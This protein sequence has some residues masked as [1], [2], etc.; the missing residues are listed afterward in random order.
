[1]IQISG[2]DESVYRIECAARCPR[3][4]RVF[5]RGA[6]I[7]AFTLDRSG[8]LIATLR[9]PLAAGGGP[10]LAVL[11]DVAGRFS[12]IVP[13]LVAERASRPAGRTERLRGF[14]SSV[15]CGDL[16]GGDD[17]VATVTTPN[18]L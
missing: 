10:S 6:L 17:D 5:R 15:A 18:H 4:Y 11:R 3:G 13:F 9:E 2:K 8:A 1:M 16:L 14:A 7:G 12:K